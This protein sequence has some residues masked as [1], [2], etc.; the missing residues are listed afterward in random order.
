MTTVT[1][2]YIDGIR[3]GREC[4]TLGHEFAYE[5]DHDPSLPMTCIHCGAE[6]TDHA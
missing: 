1:Q 6:K 3:E 4:Q 2:E 5:P